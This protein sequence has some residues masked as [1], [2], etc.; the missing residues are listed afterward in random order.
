MK[1]NEFIQQLTSR[2]EQRE[3]NYERGLDALSEVRRQKPLHIRKQEE[4]EENVEKTTL[5]D[6]KR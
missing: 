1:R 4:Y 2:I 5:E 6:R 3:E